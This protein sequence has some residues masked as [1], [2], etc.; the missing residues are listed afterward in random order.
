MPVHF[1][2]PSPSLAASGGSVWINSCPNKSSSSGIEFL[3]AVVA[4]GGDAE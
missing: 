3:E 1:P 2:F 4:G